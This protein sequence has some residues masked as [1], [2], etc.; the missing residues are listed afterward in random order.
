MKN[1]NWNLL[2]PARIDADIAV[3]SGQTLK[4]SRAPNL[5]FETGKVPVQ[6]Q[7]FV[8]I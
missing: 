6:Y 5:G 4:T 2:Q 1:V 7:S 3:E 8:S